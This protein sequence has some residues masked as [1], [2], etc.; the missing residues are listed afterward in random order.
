MHRTALETESKGSPLA[1]PLGTQL[2]LSVLNWLERMYTS[3][4]HRLSCG[5]YLRVCE[6]RF[7]LVLEASNLSPKP[8]EGDI[9]PCGPSVP[10]LIGS[11]ELKA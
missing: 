4:L 7:S 6:A 9:L 3:V 1:C 11:L 8:M 10:N 5:V 2:L